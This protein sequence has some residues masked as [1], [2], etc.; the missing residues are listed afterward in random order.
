AGGR[1]AFRADNHANW[2]ERATLHA[3]SPG[4]RLDRLIGDPK[5]LS[6][7]VSFDLPL[8]GD[9]SGLRALHLQCHIGTD[10]VSLARL[11]AEVTG[12]DFSASAVAA[13]RDLAARCKV[14]A[15]FVEGDA[16]DA[17]QL[18]GAGSFDLVYTGIGA[19]CW[20]PRIDR[21]ARVVSELMPVGGRIFVR[22]GHPMLWSI[23]EGVADSLVVGYP[24]FETSTPMTFD[25]PESYV[26]TERNLTASISHSWNHGLGEIVTA[27]LDSG[28]SITSF[29]E[30][31]SVPW[32]ALPGQM[33]TREPFGEWCM[34]ERGERLPLSYTLTATRAQ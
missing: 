26:E 28:M 16:Y 32:E 17:V 5:A 34:S 4:Y 21:W 15:T 19:L 24:Y 9:I 10:T 31:D 1:E 12:L 13:A 20:L 22:E 25:E 23:D 30:H 7:V 2:D 29:T 14:D 18:L 33:S 27:L 6:D 3:A 8:L 11:G